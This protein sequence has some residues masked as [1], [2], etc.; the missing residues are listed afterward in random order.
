MS[1][2]DLHH[3]SFGTR[4]AADD[5]L[6]CAAELLALVFGPQSYSWSFRLW[7]GSLVHCGSEPAASVVHFKSRELFRRLLDNLSVDALGEAYIHGDIDLEGD[8]F[9]VMERCNYLDLDCVPWKTKLKIWRLGR[10]I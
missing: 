4:M 10:R 1:L 7:D 9:D 2:V 3:P 5:S 6:R 8:L